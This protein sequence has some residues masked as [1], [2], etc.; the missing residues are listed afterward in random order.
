MPILL[1]L[2]FFNIMWAG[3]VLSG[4]KFIIYALLSLIAHISF[5]QKKVAEIK[6]IVL[7][8]SIGACIDLAL[9]R[10]DIFIFQSSSQLPAWLIV[11][12]A[13]FAATLAHSL[14]FLAN[15]RLAQWFMG[16]F[17]APIS[18]I[19]GK[20]LGAVDFTLTNIHTYLILSVIWGPLFLLLFF[21]QKHLF[22]KDGLHV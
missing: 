12:W 2:M 8:V 18:Y 13:C 9:L 4:N 21:I 14:Q 20:S 19:A 3:L 1:N 7:V 16:T 22:T 17:I 10:L 6:L 11:L 15:S 5:C